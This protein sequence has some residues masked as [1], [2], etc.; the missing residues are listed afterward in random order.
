[1]SAKRRTTALVSG[2]PSPPAISRARAGL[3]LPATSLI[4]PFLADIDASPRALLETMF[5]ISLYPLTARFDERGDIK[6]GARLA[7]RRS[8]FS[9]AKSVFQDYFV[10]GCRTPAP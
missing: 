8:S 4:E 5:S 9:C 2:S 3:E 6:E 1:M 10:T 7:T